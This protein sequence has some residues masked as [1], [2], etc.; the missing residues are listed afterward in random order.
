MKRKREGVQETFTTKDVDA[1]GYQEK[2]KIFKMEEKVEDT[3]RV[4]KK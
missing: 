2:E 4:E 1:E 3:E